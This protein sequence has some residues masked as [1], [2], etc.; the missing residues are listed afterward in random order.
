MVGSTAVTGS[1][2]AIGRVGNTLT[3]PRA[4]TMA[5]RKLSSASGSGRS[6]KCEASGADAAR[7]LA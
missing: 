1:A 7:P 4:G 3:S 2:A 6:L 5:R